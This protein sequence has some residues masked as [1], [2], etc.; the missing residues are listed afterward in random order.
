MTEIKAFKLISGE[1]LAGE[2]LAESATEFHLT[3]VRQL[4]L[5]QIQVPGQSEPQLIP[6]FVPWLLSNPEGKDI[7]LYRTAISALPGELPDA[8]EKL[9]IEQTSGLDLSTK[10]K[11]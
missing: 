10:I 7:R 9:Y 3:K 1:E 11:M 5:V 8:L 2:V 6:Q 4:G